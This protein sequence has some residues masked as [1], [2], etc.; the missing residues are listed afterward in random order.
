MAN[1]PLKTRLPPETMTLTTPQQDHD[2]KWNDSLQDWLDGDLPTAEVAAFEAHLAG[3]E[4]CQTLLAQLRELDASLL[5][6][7]PRLELDA[8]FDER[9]FAQID[10]IDETQRAKARAQAEQEFQKNLSNLTRGWRRALAFVIPGLIGGVALAFAVTGF[11][12]QSGLAGEVVQKS[13]SQFGTVGASYAHM[14]LTTL[15]GAGIGAG[16][17][18]W[19]STAME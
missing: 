9:L 10:A 18:R 15:I 6:A 12:D 2:L 13:A 19:L 1:G 4:A 14:L 11:F 5:A 7:A 3:C 16:L 8:A 17:A